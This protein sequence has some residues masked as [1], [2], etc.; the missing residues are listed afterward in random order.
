MPRSAEGNHENVVETVELGL[1]A[2]VGPAAPLARGALLSERFLVDEWV[3]RGGMGDVYRGR[4]LVDQSLVAIKAIARIHPEDKKR[5]VREAA[6]LATLSHPAIVQYVAHGYMPCGNPFLVMRWLHGR[7]L[8]SRLASSPLSAAETWLLVRRVCEGLQVAHAR[9]VMH[10]DIKPSNLMLVD[11]DPA[12]VTLVDFGVARAYGTQPLTCTG[13]VLGTIGYMAPEQALGEVDLDPRVDVFAL[14]C[15]IYECLTG[16][17]AFGG[18][19]TVA[20]LAKVLS[21][22]PPR[23]SVHDKRLAV[24]DPL[25]TRLLSRDRRQR[26]RDAGEV[27]GMLDDLRSSIWR[28][29]RLTPARVRAAVSEQERCLVAVL[30]CRL[31]SECAPSEERAPQLEALERNGL[32]MLGAALEVQRLGTTGLAFIVSAPH[33]GADSVAKLA[34]FACTLRH[35]MSSEQPVVASA[36]VSGLL[37]TGGHDVL[38][39]LIEHASSLL[40]AQVVKPGQT[41][42][43]GRSAELLRASFTLAYAG[44]HVLLEEQHHE[45]AV[46]RL[47]MGKRTPCVG[48]DK[49]LSLLL[50]TL[51]E[52]RSDRVVRSVLVTAEPGMGKSRLASELQER[53]A[54]VAEAQVLFARGDAMAVGS[55]LALVQQLIMSGLGLKPLASLRERQLR[56]AQCFAEPLPEL[57]RDPSTLFVAELV[58]APFADADEPLLRAARNDPAM[59][60]EQKRRAFVRFILTL[61]GRMPLLIVID[62][63]HWGDLASVSYINDAL[64]EAGDRAIMLCAFARP[65]VHEQFPSLW[66][67]HERQDIRL[68][69]LTPRA[70]ERLVTAVL[71]DDAPRATVARVIR[72]AEGNAFYI[73]ELLR[74]VVQGGHELP[75]SLLAIA[76]ARLSQLHSGSRRVLRAASAFGERFWGGAV[77]HLLPDVADVG[78]ELETFV[79]QEL[80][81]RSEE[82]GVAGEV[83]YCFRH[84]LLREAAYAMLTEED[85]R[86]AHRC[87]G[88]WL[89]DH[90][91]Q[92]ADVL[93]QHFE[94]GGE[95]RLAA[96]WLTRAARAALD[97]GDI[98]RVAALAERGLSLGASGTDRGELLVLRAFA[99]MYSDRAQPSW[100]E[101]ALTLIPKGTAFWWLG[102]SLSIWAAA[103]EGCPERAA[104]Y[105]TLALS[106]PDAEV[107]GP[108]G[109]AVW[110][111][112]IGLIS[113]KQTDLASRIIERFERAALRDAAS[114][115]ALSGWVALA[116][117]TPGLT[118]PWSAPELSGAIEHA[119]RARRNMRECGT[120]VGEVA[121]L[122]YGAIA[123]RNIGGY[124]AAE[125]M[126]RQADVLLVYAVPRAL[127]EIVRINQAWLALRSGRL[128]AAG[129]LISELCGSRNRPLALQAL[130]LQAELCYRRGEFER[131]RAVALRCTASG[132]PTAE[133]WGGATLARVQLALKQPRAAL[134]VTRALLQEEG[135]GHEADTETDLYVSQALALSTLG[136]VLEAKRTLVEVCERIAGTAAQFVD[137]HQRALFRYGIESHARAAQLA[138]AWGLSQPG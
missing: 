59:M 126:L 7:D 104:P 21:A 86:A 46:P 15:L 67:A 120:L 19:H 72:L 28:L 88:E 25:L 101:E 122:A 57:P 61:S 37:H 73:E 130:S 68:P 43:D 36:L 29:R 80:L 71:G 20:V 9:G 48:R 56:C 31:P 125:N 26:P 47:L 109:Q 81:R 102:V 99:C 89:R 96:Q 83:E 33:G 24:F 40:N 118:H 94:L 13:T 23:L 95:P 58:G 112:V 65:Q 98:E 138:A 108:H 103:I 87:A 106:A 124:G 114:D 107:S 12:A 92:E 6:V 8:A 74:Q 53:A 78:F 117:C 115:L 121:A 44:G 41:L 18:R 137:P 136:E 105:I 45:A 17:L 84:A 113:V 62:D 14:G 111:S 70:A 133:R 55:A 97:A 90:K 32:A 4:D 63:L 75:E 128:A 123:N 3:S 66:S 39:G 2:A 34:R 50:A 11:D 134:S 100:F 131:S 27:L 51:G 135:I 38:S 69:R 10:R 93:A 91:G 22:E 129:P 30:L 49:E 85:R 1:V 110:V 35:G 77:R 52:C 60:S 119:E 116:R 79:R 54:G 127:R 82:S 132:Y 42:L 5:F 16:Q 76:H 64:N